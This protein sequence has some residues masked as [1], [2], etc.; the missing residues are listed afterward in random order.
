MC[1]LEAKLAVSNLLR[2]FTQLLSGE[3]KKL[4][5]LQYIVDKI[6]KC[7]SESHQWLFEHN[8]AFEKDYI[9]YGEKLKQKYN[10]LVEDIK[11]E[12]P[13]IVKG[14]VHCCDNC[15]DFNLSDTRILIYVMTQ[16]GK[17]HAVNV[18]RDSSILNLKAIIEIKEGIACDNQRL[19]F[20]GQQLLDDRTLS[21]YNVRSGSVIHMIL[22]LS[23]TSLP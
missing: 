9:E 12:Q 15:I 5:F 10:S 17:K 16:S 20:A 18:E 19:I 4:L 21:H 8:Y 3:T 2:K 6:N 1:R 22:R 13:R 23:G 7:V 11:K 14:K